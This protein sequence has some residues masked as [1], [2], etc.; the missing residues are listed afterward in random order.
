MA[1]DVCGRLCVLWAIYFLP[2]PTQALEIHTSYPG[3]YEAGKPII[4]Q[5]NVT[6][7]S[8]LDDINVLHSTK[9]NLYLSSRNG[10][11]IHVGTQRGVNEN[12]DVLTKDEAQIYIDA[13]SVIV[14]IH[15]LKFSD[16]YNFT[17]E[18]VERK[19]TPPFEIVGRQEKAI[20][21]SDVK[22]LTCAEGFKLIS[23]GKFCE[24]MFDYSEMTTLIFIIVPTSAAL[25]VI[26]C[27]FCYWKSRQLDR[28][29]AYALKRNNGENVNM[30]HI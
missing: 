22:N 13:S 26:T 2:P 10:T 18:A 9:L 17:L 3:V 5:W 21:V 23:S 25:L 14:I 11:K 8:R 27:G 24:E 20:V 1:K 30:V 28:L 6:F 16:F 29:E 19:K 12:F 7:S 15:K 4:L